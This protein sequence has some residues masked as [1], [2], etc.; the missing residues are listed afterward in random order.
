M[1]ILAIISSY[2][3]SL[4]KSEQKV[5]QY[6]LSNSDEVVNLSINE[7]ALLSEVG[8]STIVRFTRKI[9]FAGFQDFKKELIR[10]ES[11]Q[12][13]VDDQ[14]DDTPKE[15]T[16]SH[17]LKSLTETKGFIDTEDID[18]AAQ[19]LYCAKKIYIFAVGTS[20]IT[21]QHISNR[22]K[23]LGM[24][25]EY[26][27]DS[28]LQSIDAA[29]TKKEDIALAISTSG[30]TKDV[31]QCVQL[32][33]QNETTII[34]ITNYL[35]SAIS[36]VA[37]ISL[38]ASSKEFSSDSGSFSATISQLYLIDILTK[39]IIEQDTSYFHEMRQKTNQ[40]LIKRI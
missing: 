33:K 31:L 6:I 10:F 19:L 7:L 39:Y 29:L 36:Q 8:E 38:V 12:T 1:D 27:Q 14:L 30:N 23:R 24:T 37:D 40:A 26:V 11:I 17:I 25:V 20:G 2:L 5:A 13:K 4:S 34:S 18:K 3:P 16:Y 32:S 22:L 9:G 15:I 35:K 21:A 28:H